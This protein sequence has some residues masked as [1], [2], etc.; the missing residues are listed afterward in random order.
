MSSDHRELPPIGPR[1]EGSRL[2]CAPGDALKRLALVLPL[3]LLAWTGCSSTPRTGAAAPA[4]SVD[5]A[6]EAAARAWATVLPSVYRDCYGAVHQKPEL[7]GFTLLESMSC[8]TPA[9]ASRTGAMP[10]TAAM[11]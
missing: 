7:M 11:A 3:A 6:K 4:A 2:S 1:A 9:I 8:G 5:A 10:G